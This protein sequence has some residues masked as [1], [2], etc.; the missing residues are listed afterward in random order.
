MSTVLRTTALRVL[1]LRSAAHYT[2]GLPRGRS[3]ARAKARIIAILRAARQSGHTPAAI[4][5]A[6]QC[7]NVPF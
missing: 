7:E 1:A 2:Y 4:A 6:I 3:Q 5:F